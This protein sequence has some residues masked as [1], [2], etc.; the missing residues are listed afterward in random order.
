MHPY[1]QSNDGHDEMRD[2]DSDFS[3][4]SEEMHRDYECFPDSDDDNARRGK[5]VQNRKGSNFKNEMTHSLAIGEADED[6]DEDVQVT[7]KSHYSH[8]ELL[9]NRVANST[10]SP[11]TAYSKAT[12]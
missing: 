6:S 7:R 10:Q 5:S 8:R 2:D 12:T 4:L 1:L 11:R 9:R 3:D